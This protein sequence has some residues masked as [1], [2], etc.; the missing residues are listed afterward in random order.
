MRTRGRT[1]GRIGGGLLAAG[2]TAGVVAA[3]DRDGGDHNRND[4]G[5]VR[6]P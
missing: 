1:A 6:V 4:E 5:G 3:V 2:G